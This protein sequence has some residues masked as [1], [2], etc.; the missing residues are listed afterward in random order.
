MS[1]L[2]SGLMSLGRRQGGAMMEYDTA[3]SRAAD[4]S[5]GVRRKLAKRANVQP[6]ILYFLAEDADPGVR[7]EIAANPSTPVQADAILS[8]DP[9]AVVRERIA[10]KI[11]S[12]APEL[13]VAER[14]RAGEIV[15]G[16]LENLARDEAVKIRRVLA[17]S[18]KDAKGIP[19]SVVEKLAR[20]PDEAV[21]VPVLGN[22]PL[23]SDEFLV[24][25]IESGPVR[26]AL[27]AISGRRALGAGVADAIV[28]TDDTEV[29]T[30]LLS[31]T[32][33]QIREETLDRI[34]DGAADR[35]AWHAPLVARPSLSARAGS[36]LSRFVTDALLETLAARKDLDPAVTDAI[37]EGVR[38]RLGDGEADTDDE[39]PASEKVRRLFAE[40]RLTESDVKAAMMRGD[41]QFVIEAIAALGGVAVPAVR[42]AFSLASAKGV[43]ALSWKAGLSA[44]LAHQLQLRLAKVSPSEAIK[45]RGGNY[46]LSEKDLAWQVEFFGG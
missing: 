19:Q 14:E 42:K 28:A 23:L 12:L 38:R 18:L 15:T 20:D 34:V 7:A 3:K 4:Q 1:S 32:S 22:S 26:A 9:D 33:A 45:P 10:Y 29:I 13:S 11:A 37:G 44:D 27:H 24:E 21:C 36:A 35:D 2:L 6:E 39:E 31:N 16:I 5:T 43:A 41:R 25:I 17:D 40:Q 8:T 30:T 46:G